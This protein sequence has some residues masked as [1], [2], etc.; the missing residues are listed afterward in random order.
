MLGSRIVAY[1]FLLTRFAVQVYSGGQISLNGESDLPLW[2]YLVPLGDIAFCFYEDEEYTVP[3][4]CSILA[5]G[6]MTGYMARIVIPNL[7]DV[8]K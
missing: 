3:K 6:F 5:V 8:E 2:F 7:D 1:S 4:I